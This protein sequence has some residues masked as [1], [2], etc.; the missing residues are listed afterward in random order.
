[1]TT[2]AVLQPGY[3]PW[4]GFFEQMARADHFVYYDDVH[5][6]KHGWRNRNRVKGPTGPVWLSVPVRHSG[7]ADQLIL[8]TEIVPDIPWA[9]KQIRTLQ[10]LYAKAPHRDPYLAEF[11]EIIEHPWRLISDLDMAVGDVMRGWFGITTPIYRSSALGIGGG[12]SERLVNICKNFGATRYVSGA[13]ARDYLEVT[14]F[15]RA[16]IEV[17]WQ[18]Y[19]HPTYPQLHGDFV[20]HLSALDLALNV[21]ASSRRVILG[22]PGH[23]T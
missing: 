22:E 18:D 20:S 23:S 21:G 13:A 17:V 2:V 7:R 3:I 15:D 16:G 4:L 12:Q 6:D 14:L 9:K 19:R 10:Q 11:A 8:E 1:M 5:F